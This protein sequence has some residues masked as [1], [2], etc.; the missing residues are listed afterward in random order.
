MTTPF[1]PQ[2]VK[3][4]DTLVFNL[5]VMLR[6]HGNKPIPSA[7]VKELYTSLDLEDNFD[8]KK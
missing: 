8:D 2:N 6:E 3:D 5:E 1:I 7:I 4:L